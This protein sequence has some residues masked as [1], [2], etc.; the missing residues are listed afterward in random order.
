MLLMKMALVS[1]NYTRSAAVS[2]FEN[3]NTKGLINK[4]LCIQFLMRLD[5]QFSFM[6]ETFNACGGKYGCCCLQHDHAARKLRYDKIRNVLLMILYC[7]D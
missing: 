6:W 7:V 2:N 4:E 1:M 3:Y 5:A